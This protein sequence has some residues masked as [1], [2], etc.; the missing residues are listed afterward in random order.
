MKLKNSS[1]HALKTPIEALD[2]QGAWVD[3]GTGR[4][5]TIDR[6]LSNFHRPLQRRAF[7]SDPDVPLPESGVIRNKVTGETYLLGQSRHDTDETEAYTRLSIVHFIS[8]ED[9]HKFTIRRKVVEDTRPFLTI[10]ELVD[11]EIG[12][13]YGAFEFKQ[14]SE[15][16]NAEDHFLTKFLFF[17]P[18]N[19]DVEQGDTI[20]SDDG[21]EFQVEGH[22][23]D[24]DFISLV[25]QEKPDN[26]VTGTYF[27]PTSEFAYDVAKGTV[28]KVYDQY[29]F[30]CEMASYKADKGLGGNT[31]D[32]EVYVKTPSFPLEMQV[33]FKLQ[34]SGLTYMIQRIE[35]NYEAGFQTRLLCIEH[36]L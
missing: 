7:L 28:N 16:F 34:V 20:I 23:H 10:G 32:T 11:Q 30:T 13:F 18:K 9:D 4:F 17:F 21:R 1:K 24:S 26:R 15:T 35:K 22:Y 3:W 5:S 14:T 29:L 25:G 2:A 27:V 8:T 33:G 6:F 31:Y 36:S 12:T 19:V